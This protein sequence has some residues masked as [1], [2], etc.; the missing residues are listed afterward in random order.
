MNSQLSASD[1]SNGVAPGLC[2]VQVDKAL[3]IKD[4]TAYASG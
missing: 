4:K 1:T 2:R 3:R